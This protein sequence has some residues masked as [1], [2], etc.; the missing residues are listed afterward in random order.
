VRPENPANIGACARVVR[1]AGLQGLD[2][3]APGDYRTLECWRTAWGAHEVLEQAR[4]FQELP[5]A[6]EPAEYVVAF[7]GRRRAEGPTPL[8]VRAAAS[9]VSALPDRAQAALVFGPEANGLTNAEIAACGRAASIPS[10]PG[11]PSYNL[12]HAVA[13]AAYEVMRAAR[14]S[15]DEPRAL[16]S[17]ADKERLLALLEP[18]LLAIGALPRAN[19]ASYFED[20]RALIQRADLTPRELGLLEHLARKLLP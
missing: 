3:V 16:A 2:L 1:N 10:D 15:R 5:P 7:T 6:L 19:T 18:G 14:P 17:H 8:D 13:I 20:W 11:Q 12:S 9:A 4:E